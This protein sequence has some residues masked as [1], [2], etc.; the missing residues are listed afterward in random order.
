MD[1]DKTLRKYKIFIPTWIDRY[2]GIVDLLEIE[3]IF[4]TKF[5]IIKKNKNLSNRAQ[6][7][8]QTHKKYFAFSFYL[9]STGMISLSLIQSIFIL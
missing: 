5:G 4:D 6:I 3:E 8:K 9:I 2:S 1:I 7:N